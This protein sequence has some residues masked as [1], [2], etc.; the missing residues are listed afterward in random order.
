MCLS[1]SAHGSLDPKIHFSPP[2]STICLTPP[3]TPAKTLPSV[4]VVHCKLAAINWKTMAGPSGRVKAICV[5]ASLC[6]LLIYSLSK[7]L[8]LT[9]TAGMSE[10]IAPVRYTILPSSGSSDYQE[11]GTRICLCLCHCDS[12]NQF[13][14]KSCG[15]DPKR[16]G[17]LFWYKSL[18]ELWA[19]NRTAA[20]DAI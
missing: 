15:V 8:L 20:S 12:A 17:D 4:S 7:Q 5:V 19:T 11:N 1:G 9:L 13:W 6:H 18:H 10:H 2:V 16:T 3:L 14:G